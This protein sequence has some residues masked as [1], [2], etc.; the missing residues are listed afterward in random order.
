MSE[1]I[2]Q[3]VVTCSNAIDLATRIVLRVAGTNS[4]NTLDGSPMSVVTLSALVGA[5]LQR[6]LLQRVGANNA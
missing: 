6:K 1:K 3:S 4:A 2:N 5:K